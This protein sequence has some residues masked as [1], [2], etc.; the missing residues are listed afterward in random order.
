MSLRRDRWEL[1]VLDCA[2]ETIP[3][4][5]RGHVATGV[6]INLEVADVDAE[7]RRLVTD[8]PLRAALEIRTED[9]GQRHFIVTAPDGVLV[10]VI[11][12]TPPTPEFAERF[13]A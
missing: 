5:H 4:V 7:Y 2:H 1:A 3:A 6:L 12:P 11:S 9:F 13:T 8:G 10:D